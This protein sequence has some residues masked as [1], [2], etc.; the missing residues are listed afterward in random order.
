MKCSLCGK[1]RFLESVICD[2]CA[3]GTTTTETTTMTYTKY[4][5][6]YHAACA[7]LVAFGAYS[8][9]TKRGRSLV[10]RA[11]WELR[12]ANPERAARVRRS[13][14][15]ISGMFPVKSCAISTASKTCSRCMG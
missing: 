1:V 13:M 15:S 12:Y 9:N 14:L 10:A 2:K 8:G 6:A 5:K 11:L 3:E 4:T 7:H